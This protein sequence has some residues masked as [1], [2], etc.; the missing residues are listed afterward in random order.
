MK[1]NDTIFFY[2]F[3]RQTFC[4]K[5]FVGG[6]SPC[7]AGGG[8]LNIMVPPHAINSKIRTNNSNRTPNNFNHALLFQYALLF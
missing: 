3:F 4:L 1:K 8:A 2:I 5:Q 6:I 7:R